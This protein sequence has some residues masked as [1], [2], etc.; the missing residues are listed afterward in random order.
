MFLEVLFCNWQNHCNFNKMQRRHIIQFKHSH[1][2]VCV[3]LL[4]FILFVCS[5]RGYG[6]VK[7]HIRKV[8]DVNF[9]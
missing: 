7:A 2:R 9:E 3:A 6:N 8:I 1:T 4:M 5:N